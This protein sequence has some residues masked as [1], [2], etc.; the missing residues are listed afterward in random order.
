MSVFR[1]R[2]EALVHLFK[3][4]GAIFNISQHRWSYFWIEDSNPT[5][6]HIQLG[7][8]VLQRCGSRSKVR[9]SSDPRTTGMLNLWV[10]NS[11]LARIRWRYETPP[12]ITFREVP[13]KLG[14]QGLLRIL[15][16]SHSLQQR[17]GILMFHLQN[18]ESSPLDFVQ[19]DWDRN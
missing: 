4:Q 12:D 9:A 1:Q 18:V 10:R 13:S 3:A 17:G 14:W 6:Q 7:A 16:L 19:V 11:W 2:R 15:P 8:R 5:N